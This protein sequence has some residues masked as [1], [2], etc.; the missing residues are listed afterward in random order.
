MKV[1]KALILAVVAAA[2]F[3]SSWVN[4]AEAHDANKR[5]RYNCYQ[6]CEERTEKCVDQ[7]GRGESKC[8]NRRSTCRDNCSEAY[9][10]DYNH[11]HAD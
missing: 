8:W 3:Q 2:A 5:A 11:Y 6:K 7:H 10:K 4:I 1:I 9:E